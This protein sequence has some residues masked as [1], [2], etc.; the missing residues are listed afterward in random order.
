LATEQ[1]TEV[2][3]DS[4]DKVDD[5]LMA[6]CSGSEADQDVDSDDD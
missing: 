1:T 2:L 4:E 6:Y 5:T 3:G